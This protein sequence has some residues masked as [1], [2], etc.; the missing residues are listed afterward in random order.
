VERDPKQK[1]GNPK[2]TQSMRKELFKSPAATS[3]FRALNLFLL[4]LEF[5]SEFEFRISSPSPTFT[6]A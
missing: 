5:V 1:I 4:C 2:Q 6:A 3:I